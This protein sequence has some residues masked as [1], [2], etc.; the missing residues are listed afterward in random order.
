MNN[1]EIARV[2]DE[3]AVLLEMQDVEWKPRAYRQAARRLEELSEPVED[4]RERGE[5]EAIDGIGDTIAADVRAYLDEGEIER[6]RELRDRYPV[7]A[8]ALTRV[9]G[10]GPKTV[11]RLYEALGVQDLD[12]LEAA[13]VEGR[14]ARVEG[15]GEATQQ[16]ILDHIGLAREGDERE[17]LGKALPLVT[18][19]VDELSQRDA[20]EAIEP[21]GSVRRRAPTVG[22]VDL[23]ARAGDPEAAMDA[24]TGLDDVDR[25]FSR[26]DT[27]SS[28]VLGAGL[29]V[30]LRVVD[31][32]SW[33]SALVYFTGSKNHNIR[34]RR[35]AQDRGWKL[36]EYGLFADEERLAGGTEAEVYE[37]LDLAEIPPELREDGGEVLAA[38]ASELPDLVTED[39]IT[40]DMQMHTEWSDGAGSIREMAEA[41]AEL[42]HAFIL[43]TDHGPDLR[44]AGGPEE[45]DITEI[46]AEAER[47]EEA[48]GVRV[49]V[50]I[51][52]NITTKGGLDISDQACREL[53][54]VVASLHT[55]AGDATERIAKAIGEHPVDVLA[56]PTNRRIG[57]REPNEL[58]LDRLAEVCAE[59]GV[60]VEINAQ[61]DRLDLPWRQVHRHREAFDW[62][63][64]TDAHSPGQL[65]RMHLGLAQ[66]RKAWLE[67]EDVL[68][69]RDPE[70]VVDHLR[71]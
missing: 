62:V 18:G 64:S 51:E 19:L 8:L 34:L 16:R 29:Q 22:D 9:E 61:P 30:D 50:G 68:N 17:L 44:V 53:D 56:H 36:N 39:D 20:F 2:L 4:V 32:D 12:Q 54:L 57:W 3:I 31:A 38:E 40:G 48:T 46:R 59:Q 10:V 45:D 23:L 5:L 71:G 58:D 33:G 55:R 42:G 1:A 65:G 67:P 49:L 47:A 63:V 60:A 35:R 7:D 70:E 41:A 25:V 13:A 52:A 6:H 66:A 14:V 69:T 28:I 27:R 43:L 15:F 26:G 11:K 21:V 24:F 37:A